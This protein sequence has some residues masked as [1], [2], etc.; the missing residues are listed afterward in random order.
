MSKTRV[1][2]EVKEE[3]RNRIK[4]FTE[5]IK[6]LA[7]LEKDKD[8]ES[9]KILRQGAEGA[10]EY[11]EKEINVLAHSPTDNATKDREDNFRMLG[12]LDL[13]GEGTFV[14]TRKAEHLHRN[15]NSIGINLELLER[16]PFESLEVRYCGRTLRTTRAF[17]LEH[18]RRLAF[19][20]FEPQIFLPLDEW[21]A[22]ET[23]PLKVVQSSQLGLFAGSEVV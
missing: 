7:L 17:L 12:R 23:E 3:I 9:F 16:F 5:R 14:T 4:R 19:G 22:I 15:T 18:G 20:G 11:T 21:T 6:R 10:V 1:S 13:S 2:E 8:R